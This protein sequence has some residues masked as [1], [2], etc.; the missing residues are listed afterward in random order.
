EGPQ[1]WPHPANGNLLEGAPARL[2]TDH[3]F[4]TPDGR[5]RFA[6]FHSRGLAEP[7]DPDYPFVLTVGRLY[8]HWHTQTR[9]GR[10]DKITQ[11]HPNPFIEIHPRDAAKL[12]IQ[13][14]E[15]VEVRSRRGVARFP[16]KVTQAISPGTVFVPMHWG[17]LWAKDAEANVL[18]HSEACPIS[19]E[20]ELKACAVQLVKV[21]ADHISADTLL[22]SPKSSMLSAS[23]SI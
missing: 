8:G 4:H 17:A 9:T 6:A 15:L 16:A 23:P 20:P 12:G 2:Y 7:P 22:R 3:R 18:T 14:A 13:E 21:T 1:Q 5:A 10:I 19:L 11:M